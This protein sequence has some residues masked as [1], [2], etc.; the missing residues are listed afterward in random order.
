M[1]ECMY[2]SSVKFYFTNL[3]HVIVYQVHWLKSKAQ[4]DRWKEEVK[5][6]YHEMNFCVNFMKHM[7]GCWN[8]QTSEGEGDSPKLVASVALIP[9]HH[10]H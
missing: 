9:P 5:L 3:Q 4:Q 1:A 8:T 7:E 6:L 10:V 2:I